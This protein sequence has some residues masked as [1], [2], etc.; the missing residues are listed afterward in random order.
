M[1]PGPPQVAP[2]SL[3]G[4]AAAGAGLGSQYG[5]TFSQVNQAGQL[6]QATAGAR[7]AD[8]FG[9]TVTPAAVHG[10]MGALMLGAPMMAYGAKSAAW[11][12]A[13]H[14][15]MRMDP[16]Y[17]MG[18]G[19]RFGFAMAKG[20]TWAGEAGAAG[21]GALGALRSAWAAGSVR[22]VA[23]G[24]ARVGMAG[25]AGASMA[26][27]PMAAGIALTE[28][29]IQTGK[30]VFHGAHEGMT[31][32]ALLN[33]MNVGRGSGMEVGRLLADTGRDIGK[34]VG[35][36]ADLVR[37]MDRMKMFQTTRDVKEFKER[38]TEI[39]DTVKEVARTMQTSVDEALGMVGEMRNQGFYTSSDIKSATLRQEARSTMS[40]LSTGQ[41]VQAGRFGSQYARA[42][43]MRG[44]FGSDFA[45]QQAAGVATAVRLGAMDEE[46]VE[47]RGGAAAVGANLAAT[48]MR[49][50]RSSRGRVMIANMLGSGN[51]MDPDR[52]NRMLSG[53]MTLESMVTGAANRGLGVL[54]AAGSSEARENAMQYAGMGMVA[55]AAAQ[56]QQIHGGTS[57][58]GIVGMLGTMGVGRQD[59]NLLLDQTLAMPKVLQQQ[60]AAEFSAAQRAD[61]EDRRQHHGAWTGLTQRTWIND[62]RSGARA[63]GRDIYGVGSQMYGSSARLLGREREYSGGADLE[64]ANAFAAK[65]NAG[66]GGSEL[67][68]GAGSESLFDVARTGRLIGPPGRDEMVRTE[69]SAYTVGRGEAQAMRSEGGKLR[70]LG[71]GRY[72][73]EEGEREGM[74]AITSA[75]SLT[76]EQRQALRRLQTEAGDGSVIEHSKG[77]LRSQGVEFHD[78]LGDRIGGALRSW[79]AVSGLGGVAATELLRDDSEYN[80]YILG[81]TIDELTGMTGER[82]GIM[83][84]KS[85]SEYISSGGRK[86]RT[87]TVE[88]FGREESLTD[89]G[90]IRRSDLGRGFAGRGQFAAG[91]EKSLGALGLK[92]GWHLGGSRSAI[93]G[94]YGLVGYSG[95]GKELTEA[96]Q[97][98]P[99]TRKALRKYLQAVGTDDQGKISV[100]TEGLADVAGGDA[101]AEFAATVSKDTAL[102]ERIQGAEGEDMITMLEGKAWRTQRTRAYGKVADRADK[103]AMGLADDDPLKEKIGS[104]RL[105]GELDDYQLEAQSLARGMIS[106]DGTLKED[107]QLAL[108]EVFGLSGDR[109]SQ[110][111]NTLL[112][113]EGDMKAAAKA[114]HI[115]DTS[116]ITGEAGSKE[117]IDAVIAALEKAGTLDIVGLTEEGGTSIGDSQKAYADANSRFVIAVDR[118]ISN[119]TQD[120]PDLWKPQDFQDLLE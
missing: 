50:L 14:A 12:A 10:G 95:A 18:H 91:M 30:Q 119:L 40:G 26:A 108:A 47:E 62:V 45:Q 106:S 17:Y 29:L 59:A 75:K 24:A 117:R 4:T 67:G 28:G 68:F 70:N 6:G 39:M 78:D 86:Q 88:T 3:I 34:G 81:T 120:N 114:L 52:V 35:D 111:I 116:G 66:L 48:Q 31:G 118:F 60:Q 37:D 57:R 2:P 65:L 82:G 1:Q 54:G 84:D 107:E 36:M 113:G 11:S 92:S 71:H 56:S 69:L 33:D 83:S 105:L 25:V 79:D 38:F 42:L 100:A 98:D 80:A 55:T 41:M 8:F 46:A 72:I 49:F 112:S 13:G 9:N 109:Y 51:E 7:G 94:L 74:E 101:L 87:S 90:T 20:G 115:K 23:A 110:N 44:R 102:R 19:A 53:D 16:F 43:G 15:A 73:S 103:Y 89:D 63:F 21:T 27:L 64:A 97:T 93:P 58:R 22:G 5:T 85:Y 96:L 77:V 76:K 104:L 32:T 61:Y 99:G